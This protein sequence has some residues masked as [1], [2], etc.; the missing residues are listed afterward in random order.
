[1]ELESDGKHIDPFKV[2]LFGIED[3]VEDLA[4]SR[5]KKALEDAGLS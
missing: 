1:M 5:L 3:E 2:D 4:Q